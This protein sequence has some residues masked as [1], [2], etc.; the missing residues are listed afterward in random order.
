MT[1]EA[2]RMTKGDTHLQMAMLIQSSKLQFFTATIINQAHT[3]EHRAKAKM[4][5]YI[6]M[7]VYRR[8]CTY[9]YTYF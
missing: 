3:G 8:Q 7:E 6:G 2:S 5:L 1:L 4:L 9:S